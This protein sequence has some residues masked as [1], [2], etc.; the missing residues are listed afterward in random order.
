[1]ILLVTGAGGFLGRALV[2]SVLEREPAS[3]VI[4]LDPGPPPPGLPAHFAWERGSAADSALVERLIRSHTVDAVAHLA[5]APETTELGPLMRE[6]LGF[7]LAVCHAVQR[8]GGVRRVLVPG[9]AAEYGL[10]PESELPIPEDRV[11]HPAGAYGYAKL[12]ECSLALQAPAK[13]GV[14]AFV[15]R[16]F[17]PVGPGQGTRFVCGSLAAQFARMR[18]TGVAP[19]RLG[20]LTPQRD[21]IDVSDA[22]EAL[23]LLLGRARPGEAYNVGTGR[24][25]RVADVLEVFQELTGLRPPPGAPAPPAASHEAAEHSVADIGKL[26][27]ATGFEPR[28][29][30]RDSLRA[31]LEA[32]VAGQ[33]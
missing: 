17:N 25:T 5:R 31:M 19:L 9:S 1:M 10:F 8:A 2:R 16:V 22:A 28:V 7:T 15:A 30:L 4:G 27:A 21:F 18:A 13:L 29:A 26:R 23:R 20:P 12:A 6:H 14:P 3:R 11:P 32:A 33:A 24:G